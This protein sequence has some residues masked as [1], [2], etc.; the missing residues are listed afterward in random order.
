CDIA[1]GVKYAPSQLGDFMADAVVEDEGS[2]AA[3]EESELGDARCGQLC[4]ARL[5]VLADL[6]DQLWEDHRVGRR[7][8][9]RG[10]LVGHN[11]IVR[12]KQPP[13]CE[14]DLLELSVVRADE[15]YRGRRLRGN[16]KFGRLKQAVH[17]R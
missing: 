3:A 17:N 2:Q 1:A 4:Y 9:S 13:Y 12:A 11:V 7:E 16:P 6:S 5:D 15:N 14:M 8:D 10:R